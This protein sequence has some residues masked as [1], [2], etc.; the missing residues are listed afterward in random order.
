MKADWNA[1][2]RE[3]AMYYVA[4]GREDWDEA[5][6]SEHGAQ[7]VA[8]HVEE[9]LAAIAGH[10]SSQSLTMLEIGCG[11]GRMTEHLA[12]LFGHVHG[13]DVS[14]EMIAQAKRRL[15]RIENV[16]LHETSG[17][18]VRDVPTE[19]VDFAFSFV[20]FQHVPVRRAV[21]A[22]VRDVHRTL[23]S[24]AL[25]KFQTQGSQE[26]DYLAHE[27]D[28]WL[29]VSFTQSELDIV[30]ETLGFEIVGASG[31]GTQYFWQWWRKT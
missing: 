13:V 18:D 16:I 26:P 5:A 15:T 27:K 1:R 10:R 3:N 14:G 24:G 11:V 4:S 6:F 23:R 22:T 21:L 31:A 28:T 29:G 25:F 20:V 7:S 9:D 12:A 30:A 17:C 8:K 2:A 19:S